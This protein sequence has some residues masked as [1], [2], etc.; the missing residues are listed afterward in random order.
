MRDFSVSLRPTAEP[1]SGTAKHDFRFCTFYILPKI[2]KPGTL[3]GRPICS[4]THFVTHAISTVV[5]TILQPYVQNSPSYIKDSL[6]LVRKLE[7]FTLPTGT[8][9]TLFS[10]DIV[11]L[12]PSIPLLEALEKIKIFLTTQSKSTEET[13]NLL[14]THKL[15]SFVMK[16]NFLMF[17]NNVYQQTQGT[18][19]G[20]PSAVVFACLFMTQ[21]EKPWIDEFKD[22]LLLFQRFIDDGFGIF[23]GTEDETKSALQKFNSLHPNIKI[24]SNT[25][26]KSTI[27]L[28]LNIYINPDSPQ[29]LQVACFQKS[30]NKYLYLPFTSYHNDSLKQ[31]FIRGELIRYLRNCSEQT[32]FTSMKIAFF[33]RLRARGYPAEFLLPIFLKVQFEDRQT[34]LFS[35]KN[36]NKFQFSDSQTILIQEKNLLSENLKLQNFFRS[37]WFQRLIP[38]SDQT[39]EATFLRQLS[40]PRIL[41][42][43]PPNLRQL[44]IRSEFN[45]F[46]LRPKTYWSALQ[47]P[48]HLRNPLEDFMEPNA[49]KFKKPLPI[50]K[51]RN[52]FAD[53][54]GPNAKRFKKPNSTFAQQAPEP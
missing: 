5:D 28:D 4:N 27:F 40:Q 23:L 50:T 11:S 46:N 13:K 26:L 19:M 54:M 48:K 47:Q 14:E 9:I 39:Q 30:M 8:P 52:P 22:K 37:H 33:G 38:I 3:K 29:K 42:K 16:N 15:L 7:T 2:H 44:L 1:R 17:D 21:L 12:Y 24:E 6:S 53:Y 43:Y 35:D 49:K 10:F 20:T 25:S 51:S 31:N 34:F 36:E 41:T 18:C 45:G 32:N